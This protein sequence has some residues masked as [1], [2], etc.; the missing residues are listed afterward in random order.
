MGQ[1]PQQEPRGVFN[2]RVVDLIGTT[3]LATKVL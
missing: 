3:R 1:Q 2:P